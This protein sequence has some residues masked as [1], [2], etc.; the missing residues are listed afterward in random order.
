MLQMKKNTAAKIGS[1]LASAVALGAIF[2]L[3]RQ[4]APAANA[5]TQQAQSATIAPANSAASTTAAQQAKASPKVT[6][7]TRAS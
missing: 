2:G 3:V 6:T 7:R 5:A 1:L 4:A